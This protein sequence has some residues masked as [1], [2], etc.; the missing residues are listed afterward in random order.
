MQPTRYTASIYINLVIGA[1]TKH[2]KCKRNIKAITMICTNVT[3]QQ[4]KTNMWAVVYLYCIFEPLD[5]IRPRHYLDNIDVS[6]LQEVEL[7]PVM[8]IKTSS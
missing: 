2:F 5:V 8:L 7:K 4:T 3:Q 6:Y 1:S